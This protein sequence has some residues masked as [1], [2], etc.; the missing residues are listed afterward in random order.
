M[1]EQTRDDEDAFLEAM[2]AL[3]IRPSAQAGG[4]KTRRRAAPK[5]RAAGTTEA[6][7]LAAEDALF[8]A[9]MAEAGRGEAEPVEAPAA[10][11]MPAWEPPPRPDLSSEDALFEKAMA[12]MDPA[13]KAVD[14]EGPQGR[15]MPARLTGTPKSLRRRIKAGEITTE[16]ELDLHGHRRDEAKA[17]LE[18]FVKQ[19]VADGAEVARVITGRGL[20][21]ADHAVLRKA[22]PEWL[23]KDL[24]AWVHE[25]VRAPQ[26][27]GGEGVLYVFLRRFRPPSA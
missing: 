26:S 20:R 23:A 10:A 3:D 25:T 16:L 8:E 22:V 17:V 4:P 6:V 5:A 24:R 13:P 27:H 9:A 14:P 1:G 7:D 2:M 12:A 11:E 19:A 15:E 21:S 18:R